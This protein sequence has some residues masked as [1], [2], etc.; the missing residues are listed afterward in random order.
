MG[1]AGRVIELHGGP[2][3][4]DGQTLAVRRAPMFR[5]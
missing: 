3:A 2:A 4:L 1:G 5:A